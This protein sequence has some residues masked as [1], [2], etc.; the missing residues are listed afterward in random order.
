VEIL[1]VENARALP[2]ATQTAVRRARARRDIFYKKGDHDRG[3]RD[4]QI[5]TLTPAT[6][7]GTDTPSNG[8]Y[9][10]RRLALAFDNE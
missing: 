1:L 9:R 5:I 8:Y 7:R 10:V 3:D 2:R 6:S 4:S